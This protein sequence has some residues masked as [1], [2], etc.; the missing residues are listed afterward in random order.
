MQETYTTPGYPGTDQQEEQMR[1]QARSA[2]QTSQKAME[3]V[4]S[5]PANVY[6]GAV[7]GSIALSALLFLVGKKNLGIFVGLWPPTL[8]NL[9][10]FT[11]QLR[12]SHEVGEAMHRM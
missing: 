2:M 1:Q 9:A 8:L 7:I 10:I 6:Y 5:L 4:E 12:P 3:Q 11:K